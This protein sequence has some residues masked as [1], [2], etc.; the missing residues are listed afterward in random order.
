MGTG[1][2]GPDAGCHE[3]WGLD[4]DLDSIGP[5]RGVGEKSA[6]KFFSPR[7]VLTI[8]CLALIPEIV[9]SQRLTT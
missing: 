1:V 8:V 9:V 4:L 7:S 5:L 2:L 3:Y 6:E